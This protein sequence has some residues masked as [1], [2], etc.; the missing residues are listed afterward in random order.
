MEGPN[1]V[2]WIALTKL[3]WLFYV[4]SIGGWSE[5][6]CVIKSVGIGVKRGTKYKKIYPGIPRMVKNPPIITTK[7]WYLLPA[8]V[9]FLDYTQ[10]LLFSESR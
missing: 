8:Y 9:E 2:I 3:L 7:G 6:I 1:S 5:V 10:C 4:S